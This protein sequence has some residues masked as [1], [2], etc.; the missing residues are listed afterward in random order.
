M[1]L[2]KAVNQTN[3]DKSNQRTDGDVPDNVKDI[4]T[5]LFTDSNF[6]ILLLSSIMFI[7]GAAV[8]LTHIRGFFYL[9]FNLSIKFYL[10]AACAIPLF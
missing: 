4:T 10:N 6:V 9:V 8:V 7:F 5:N 2:K 1:E 3:L